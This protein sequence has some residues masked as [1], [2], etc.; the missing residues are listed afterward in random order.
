MYTY[1]F[2]CVEYIFSSHSGHC[3]TR[4]LALRLHQEEILL[5][6]LEWLRNGPS[7]WYYPSTNPSSIR[8]KEKV[9]VYIN[10]YIYQE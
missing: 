10:I 6:S 4:L 5:L 3:R 7:V 1:I 9:L 2:W 8:V